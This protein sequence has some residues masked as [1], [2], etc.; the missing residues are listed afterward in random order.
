[1]K[2]KHFSESITEKLYFLCFLISLTQSIFGIIQPNQ[3]IAILNFVGR[4]GDKD[5]Q[6]MET[7]LELYSRI[8]RSRPFVISSSPLF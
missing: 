8:E 3:K 2:F 4:E 6:A 7:M 1:M 5:T